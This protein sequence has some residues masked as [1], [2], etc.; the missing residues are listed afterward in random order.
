MIF[1]GLNTFQ[2][3]GALAILNFKANRYLNVKFQNRQIYY[4]VVRKYWS[5]GLPV[6]IKD[7]LSN[8]VNNL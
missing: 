4:N 7:D 8:R 1:A 6:A 2:L 3:G 5:A